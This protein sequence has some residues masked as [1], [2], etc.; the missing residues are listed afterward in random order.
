[1]HINV[2]MTKKTIKRRNWWQSTVLT[3]TPSK[4]K[5]VQ[6]IAYNLFVWDGNNK[7]K[8]KGVPL[9]K[10]FTKERKIQFLLREIL[11]K[12][13]SRSAIGNIKSH[14]RETSCHS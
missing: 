9:V 8:W 7:L 14:R 10:T 5:Q 2:L 6:H 13:N 4:Y 11:C 1:M 3:I 12:P